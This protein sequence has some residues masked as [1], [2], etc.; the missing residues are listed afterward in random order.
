MVLLSINI[1]IN[2][3]AVKE[4]IVVS[5]SG[6]FV[7]AGQVQVLQVFAPVCVWNWKLTG[8]LILAGYQPLMGN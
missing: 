2:L 7:E 5:R 8:K 6:M 1:Q 3:S 4:V